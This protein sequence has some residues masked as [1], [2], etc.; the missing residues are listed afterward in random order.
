MDLIYVTRSPATSRPLKWNGSAVAPE[1]AIGDTRGEHVTH[2]ELPQ[3]IALRRDLKYGVFV[4]FLLLPFLVGMMAV[5]FD[6]LPITNPENPFEQSGDAHHNWV[7][8]GVN[9]A[10]RS[11]L[12]LL[13]A[14]YATKFFIGYLPVR[15]VRIYY[16]ALLVAFSLPYIWFFIV[17]DWRNPFVYRVSCWLYDPMGLWL[18][19]SISF[20]ADTI[21]MG[22]PRPIW[23]LIRSSIEL[24]FIVPWFVAWAFFSFFFLGGGWI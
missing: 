20:L 22:S 6:R 8:Q 3:V 15:W 9:T 14:V 7:G 24:V 16:F 4:S 1:F 5:C 10:Y 19:P 23:Y 2:T 11:A 21:S 13:V 17:L 18:I 12:L